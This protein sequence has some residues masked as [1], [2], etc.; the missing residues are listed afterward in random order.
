[1]SNTHS[2][3]DRML[4]MVYKQREKIEAVFKEFDED[5][6]G[7]VSDEEFAMAL[8]LLG[9]DVSVPQPC[10]A[11][12]PARPFPAALLAPARAGVSPHSCAARRP[13]LNG[14]ERGRASS[15]LR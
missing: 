4:A 13:Q 10:P 6:S 12:A 14:V 8:E 11:R 1:M 5:G 9:V 2:G 15:P 3:D 7:T